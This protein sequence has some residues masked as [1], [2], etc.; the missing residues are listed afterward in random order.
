MQLVIEGQLAL[1][2][3]KLSFMLMTVVQQFNKV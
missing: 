1:A 3:D 2:N